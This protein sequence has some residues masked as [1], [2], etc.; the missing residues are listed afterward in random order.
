[1]IFLDGNIESVYQRIAAYIVGNGKQT[2]QELISEKDVKV[3][4][5]VVSKHLS[6]EKMSLETVLKEGERVQY[7]VTAN[8]STG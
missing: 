1:M 7:V 4:R 6:N 8:V 5:E 3:D 2:I